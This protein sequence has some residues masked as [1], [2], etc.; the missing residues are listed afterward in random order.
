MLNHK[1]FSVN[2]KHVSEHVVVILNNKKTPVAIHGGSF[3]NSKKQNLSLDK[4][5]INDMKKLR[6]FPESFTTQGS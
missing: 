5:H 1:K 6:E 3:E 4:Q 2:N